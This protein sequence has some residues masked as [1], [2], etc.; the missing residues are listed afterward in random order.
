MANE[1]PDEV[2]L[3]LGKL[4]W[5]FI[6]L[7][8]LIN[9]FLNRIL[10]IFKGPI[11]PLIKNA[12]ESLEMYETEQNIHATIDW[13]KAAQELLYVRNSIMHGVPGDVI[14]DLESLPTQENSWRPV[15]DHLHPR[16][17]KFTRIEMSR[18][19]LSE[20]EREVSD[21]CGKWRETYLAF[22]KSWIYLMKKLNE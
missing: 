20:V 19:F 21:I 11:E 17:G 6:Y 8:D 22:D 15:I 14:P 5:R 13:L 10:P 4:I 1:L 18:N 7:E 9:S 3:E 16:L 2:Y 12:L